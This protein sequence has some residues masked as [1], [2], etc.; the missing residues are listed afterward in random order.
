MRSGTQ[1]WLCATFLLIFGVF[2]Y[3]LWNFYDSRGVDEAL[4]DMPDLRQK[5]FGFKKILPVLRRPKRRPV[6]YMKAA[7]N[8][9][10]A[11]PNK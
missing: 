6:Q 8:K 11:S 3:I 4:L 2:A 7:E 5:E 9:R 10:S 1:L